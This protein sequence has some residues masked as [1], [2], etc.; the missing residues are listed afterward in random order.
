MARTGAE[1]TSG[2]GDA[3][4]GATILSRRAV[5]C[6]V[7]LLGLRTWASIIRTAFLS[8]IG[9]LTGFAPESR[10]KYC[11]GGAVFSARN[12]NV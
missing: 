4:G 10:R 11:A 3:L 12:S 1:L 5:T 7:T 9:A 6:P 2:A 8:A